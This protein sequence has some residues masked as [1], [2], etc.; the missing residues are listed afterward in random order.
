MPRDVLK[1]SADADRLLKDPIFKQALLDVETDIV[2]ALCE[3]VM[4]GDA[5]CVSLTL[6]KVRDLQANRRLH[7]KLASYV[8]TGTMK[9]RQLESV[10]KIPKRVVDPRWSE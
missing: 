4:T 10:A 5:N 6:E 3:I 8:A 2:N 9:E 1:L 7:R